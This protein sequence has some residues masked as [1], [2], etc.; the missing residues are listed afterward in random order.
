MDVSA[1]RSIT[2]GVSNLE[3]ALGLFARVMALR[4][5]WRDSDVWV[6]ADGDSVYVKGRIGGCF[7]SEYELF[8]YENIPPTGRGS[9]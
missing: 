6:T 8:E 1:T 3:R 2:V 9:S 7:M 5:D 4:V